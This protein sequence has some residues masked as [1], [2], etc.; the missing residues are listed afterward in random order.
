MFAFLE[1]LPKQPFT[2][3]GPSGTPKEKSPK[4]SLGGSY[5][6][7]GGTFLKQTSQEGGTPRRDPIDK[8]D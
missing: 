8:R 6:T 1:L 3:S 4:W 5:G 2:A 7:R